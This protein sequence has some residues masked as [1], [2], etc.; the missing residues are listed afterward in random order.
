LYQHAF[1]VL[2]DI[3]IREANGVVSTVLVHSIANEVLL[4]VVR[5]DF[6]LDD[7]AFLRTKEIHDAISDDVLAPELEPA[8]LRPTDLTPRTSF[9][10]RQPLS[11]TFCS[12]D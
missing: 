5:V 12:V 6:D 1:E 3:P 8:D 4:R 9:E 11:Q 2:A 10:R 7:Q